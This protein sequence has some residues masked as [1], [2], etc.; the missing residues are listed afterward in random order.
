MSAVV[1]MVVHRSPKLAVGRFIRLRGG[2]YHCRIRI[3]SVL[4]PFLNKREIVV[5]L[6]TGRFDAAV[7]AARISRIGLDRIM[8]AVDQKLS[9]VE[10]ERRV[11]VWVAQLALE[12]EHQLAL[13]NGLTGGLM[14]AE[15]ASLGPA[16]AAHIDTM[17]KVVDDDL[18][19]EA[20]RILARAMA[21]IS[22]DHPLIEELVAT[23][24][25]QMGLSF[26][27]GSDAAKLLRR[28]ILRNVQVLIKTTNGL[29]RGESIPDDMLALAAEVALL[30]AR[31]A[32]TKH[33]NNCDKKISELWDAFCESKVIGGGWR[34]NERI[35]ARTTIKL[36]IGIA[37]DRR[38]D[39]YSVLDV[40]RF[41]TIFRNM[42]GDYYHNKVWKKVFAEKGYVG[43]SQ[44][45][46]DDKCEMT[47]TKTWN[48]HA[49][50][51]NEFWKWAA[52]KGVALKAGRTSIFEGFFI[53]IKKSKLSKKLSAALREQFE[54]EEIRRIFVTP[55]F[56]GCKSR[57]R[58][59][60]PGH[61][62][63]RD[64]RYWMTLIGFLQGMRREEPLLLKVKHVKRQDGIW[65]FDLMDA[66]LASQLK[67]IG[68]PRLIP[69]HVALLELGFIE[70]RVD[71]RGPD[72]E[73]FPEAVSHAELSRRGGP[74]GKW[75]LLF[76]R[77]CGVDR[78]KLDFHS[79]RHTVITRLLDAGVPESHVE[80]LCGHE[81]A[82]R[83]SEMATYDH[84][85]YLKTLKAAIDRL[86]IPIDI[87]RLKAAV[88]NSNCVDFTAANPPLN[89]PSI[90]PRPK[91][92][93]APSVG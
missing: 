73:L 37:G 2:T 93:R 23:A 55:T 5:S 88:Q 40:E 77:S 57:S 65:Y 20:S 19:E 29:V 21:G 52:G 67:D 6:R 80:E 58:W 45:P 15:V 47:K 81:G 24:S 83:R 75:F 44:A 54:E 28:A 13:N 30:D 4:Q 85:S 36:W 9:Q 86:A 43:L 91:R 39:D 38:I 70:A 82:E 18:L 92:K 17:F 56:L 1:H 74:F 32:E 25:H 14:S 27:P 62:V 46:K 90:V 31:A 16:G 50:R 68:S 34:G 3:P 78:D 7:R 41:R 72:E 33:P 89:D 84:G 76:R 10:I 53:E 42:P 61:F 79:C 51:L 22:A 35:S 49:S 63:F 87:G 11:R 64:H 8:E 48:K 12:R 26:E 69:L 59:K 60:K 71:R 66:A